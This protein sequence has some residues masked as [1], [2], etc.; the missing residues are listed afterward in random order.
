MNRIVI[1]G[2]ALFL[3]VVGVSLLGGENEA[4]RSRLPDL[5]WIPTLFILDASG[6]VIA[7]ADGRE[8]ESPKGYDAEKFM[9]F[10]REH[11]DDEREP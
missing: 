1:Y 10:L 8:L 11:R 9:A 6:Q 2:V 5:S 7:T 3:A 4:I